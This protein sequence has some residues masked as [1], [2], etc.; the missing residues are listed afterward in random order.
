M[1]ACM[2]NWATREK[3]VIK[4]SYSKTLRKSVI[5]VFLWSAN[6][7][8]DY[9]EILS[10]IIP[11]ERIMVY[12]PIKNWFRFVNDAIAEQNQHITLQWN[13]FYFFFSSERTS[14]AASLNMTT[15]Y[16]KKNHN[17]LGI[18]IE[19][20]YSMSSD[21]YLCAVVSCPSKHWNAA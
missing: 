14:T 3:K 12:I 5:K 20:E 21:E 16:R 9:S 6:S 8:W 1:Y 7:R 19:I 13:E 4:G 15:K 17:R 18:P 10:V 2:Q 11:N